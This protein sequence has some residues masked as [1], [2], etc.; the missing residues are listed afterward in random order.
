A[1][2]LAELGREVVSL[3]GEL[4]DRLDRGGGHRAGPDRVVG[5]GD[6]LSLE[7]DLEGTAWRA[8]DIRSLG[9]S[10]IR[11]RNSGRKLNE[12]QPSADRV[13]RAEIQRHSVE[14]LAAD[15][16]AL[17][18]ALSLEQGGC[19]RDRDGVA[20]RADFQ[21]RINAGGLQEPDLD[22]WRDELFEAGRFNT[23][24]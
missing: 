17:F 12:A 2:H 20:G 19:G 13:R 5:R 24:F 7:I 3:D 10:L 16:G 8:I 11:H 18:G 15:V 1:E 21:S 6:I 14:E 9:R 4:T 23:Q 22:S